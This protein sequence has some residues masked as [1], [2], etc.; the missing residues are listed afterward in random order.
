[1][2]HVAQ[3]ARVAGSSKRPPVE[4]RHKQTSIQSNCPV[5]HSQDGP[6]RPAL[7]R[8][9]AEERRG[10]KVFQSNCAFCHAPDGRGRNWLANFLDTQ[11]RDLTGQAISGITIERLTEVVRNGLPETSMPA[12][13][14]VLNDR[15]IRA[16]AAY[17][18]RAF[19]SGDT[20][21]D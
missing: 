4:Q 21:T 8:L 6:G 2:V 13:R 14:S 19:R 16:V 1:V 9:T 18:Y 12:W 3:G 17:V 15:D 11:P 5:C 10:E 20:G 7:A